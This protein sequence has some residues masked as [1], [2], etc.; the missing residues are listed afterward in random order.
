[1]SPTLYS[2]IKVSPHPTTTKM[3]NKATA[4]IVLDTLIFES[5][6]NCDLGRILNKD[7]YF[8]VLWTTRYSDPIVSQITHDGYINGLR[9]GCKP[10]RYLRMYLRKYHPNVLTLPVIIV[11]F[12]RFFMESRFGYDL[13]ID[14][15]TIV[16]Q[17]LYN[18]RTIA[19]IDTKTLFTRIQTF[20]QMY[21]APNRHIISEETIL[22]PNIV[23]D[24]NDL[25]DRNTAQPPRIGLRSCILVVSPTFFEQRHNLDYAQ[26]R[27]FLNSCYLVVWMDNKGVT[28]QQVQNFT[29]TL[30]HTYNIT[31]NYMLF[32][33]VHGVKSMALVRRYLAPTRLPFIII[34]QVQRLY[35]EEQRTL[36][37]FDFYI[38]MDEYW[39]QQPPR[40]STPSFYDMQAT[41]EMVQ[42]FVAS[43][44]R[45][46]ERQRR[47]N[48]VRIVEC[49]NGSGGI[50]EEYDSDTPIDQQ[51]SGRTSTSATDVLA[52]INK[53]RR[54]S[55][56]E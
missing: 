38:N 49:E 29:G 18:N 36:C 11:D 52:F 25:Y 40:S 4:V 51:A 41:V 16:I 14:I 28:R 13:C 39:R 2:L 34:D 46:L 12:E 37:D 20:V 3:V 24:S 54:M 1:M 32:G 55:M 45:L 21:N 9:N 17:Q 53:R 7:K 26:L 48:T 30:K 27:K 15:N 5:L 10:Y 31:V 19:A 47:S 43:S 33:L 6:N 23:F 22:A 35:G 56:V 42:R 8:F 44:E 50:V